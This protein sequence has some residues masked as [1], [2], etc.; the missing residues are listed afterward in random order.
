MEH[1]YDRQNT[2]ELHPKEGKLMFVQSFI[3]LVGLHHRLCE[4]K[5]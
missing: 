2:I 4:K 5:F 3:G 1:G